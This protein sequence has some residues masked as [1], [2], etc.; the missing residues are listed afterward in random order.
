VGGDTATTPERR[1]TVL[2]CDE[3]NSDDPNNGGGL[4]SI[5]IELCER[6]IYSTGRLFNPK[7]L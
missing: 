2:D 5:D 4:D 1:V 7:K 6:L 3:P